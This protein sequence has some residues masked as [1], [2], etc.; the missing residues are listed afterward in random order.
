MSL[1]L[2]VSVNSSAE[3]DD[4]IYCT[5]T[6]PLCSICYKVSCPISSSDIGQLPIRYVILVGSLC[7][8][9]EKWT[10]ISRV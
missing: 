7:P 10:C 1:F 2:S 5:L 8:T 4:D 6:V 3:A 9:H